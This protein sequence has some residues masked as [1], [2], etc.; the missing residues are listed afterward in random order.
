MS[1]ILQDI[2][3]FHN[4]RT[5]L[6]GHLHCSIDSGQHVNLIG[7]NGSGKSTL[8]QI[9]AGRL[10]PSEGHV[11]VSAN[12]Y[13]VPQQLGWLQEQT[14]AEA[15]GADRK[16]KALQAILSGK[17]DEHYFEQLADE[18]DIEERVQKALADWQLE[19]AGLNQPMRLLSG[20]E[21][22]RV[23]LAGME[24]H[25]PSIVLLDEPTN[26]LDARGRQ[27][28]YRFME[29]YKG[30][31]VAISHDRSLL[32]LNNIT[33]ALAHGR[34]ETY[35]GN[36]SFYKARRDEQLNALQQDVHHRE[37]E[38]KLAKKQAQL[39]KERRQRQEGR[40]K[41][42]TGGLPKIVANTMRNNAELSTAKLNA[43]HA[44]KM[45]DIAKDLQQQREILGKEQLLQ[46]RF[47]DSLLHKGKKLVH[48]VG[49]NFAYGKSML[50]DE[51]LDFQVNSGDTLAIRGANGA[52]KTTLLKLIMG[53]LLPTMGVLDRAPCNII[54]L[55]QQYGFIDAGKTVFEQL[56][57]SDQQR[58]PPHT[59][60]MLLHRYQLGIELWDKKCAQL[61]GGEKMKLTICCL[62]VSNAHPDMIILDEPANNLDISSLEVLTHALKAYKGTLLLVSHDAVLAE[63]LGIERFIDL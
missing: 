38:L 29:G 63:E 28:L 42:Q 55:D 26:H 22:T 51:P 56:A 20:G 27:Q 18:W 43:V 57:Q 53:T 10:A 24:L 39:A 25:V 46:L 17:T 45:D 50:W 35:G 61:S 11:T 30:T 41:S 60:K 40:D 23:M 47:P 16:V 5:L 34:L 48:A 32:E 59:L 33:V 15:L 31:L 52:G 62:F 7:N 36:Y 9:M 1:I 49:I 2:T 3:Y 6:F 19:H 14:V 8:M 12:P 21:Q 58:L 13:Y 54:Y 37:K 44:E 4:D